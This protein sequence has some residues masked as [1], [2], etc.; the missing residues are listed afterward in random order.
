MVI[1]MDLSVNTSVKDA[2]VPVDAPPGCTVLSPGIKFILPQRWQHETVLSLILGFPPP[3]CLFATE[4]WPAPN[5]WPAAEGAKTPK[6]KPAG[7]K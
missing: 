7:K 4:K 2:A 1:S 6:T 3:L 5:E